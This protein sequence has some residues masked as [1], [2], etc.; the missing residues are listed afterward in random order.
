MNTTIKS[1]AT[2]ALLAVVAVAAAAQHIPPPCTPVEGPTLYGTT[3]ACNNAKQGGACTTLST[4]VQLDPWTGA[5]IRTIGPVG[6]TVNGLAWDQKTKKLF[7]TTPPGDVTFH[8]LITIDPKTGIGTPVDPSVVNFGLELTPGSSGSPVHSISIDSKGNMVGWY[9]EFAPPTGVTDTF[10]RINKKTGKAIEFPDTGIDSSQNGVSF[11]D[12]D[13]LWNIDSPKVLPDGTL[14]QTAYLLNAMDG[15]P[16]LSKSLTPPTAAAL[17][18]FN[19][20]N[21]LYYGLNFEGGVSRHSFVVIV[22]LLKGTVTTL[23]TTVD[24][25]HTLAFAK[26]R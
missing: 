21:N 13:L 24:D 2:L 14:T 4:L 9:D 15:K 7:A 12:F 26:E 1:A 8:G 23:S 6:F 22:N 3:G 25:L 20:V 18:D 19:P 10:V 11:S 17:G 5:L 16:L